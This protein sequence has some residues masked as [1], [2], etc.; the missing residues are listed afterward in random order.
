MNVVPDEYL[1][2]AR[3]YDSVTDE[4]KKF[5]REGCDRKRIS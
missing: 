2:F 5:V 4:L 3:L 1:D